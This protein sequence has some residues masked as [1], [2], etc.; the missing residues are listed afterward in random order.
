MRASL[1][2]MAIGVAVVVALFLAAESGLVDA[3]TNGD[4]RIKGNISWSGERIYHLPGDEYYD[5]TRINT[6][7]GER[8][9]C[10]EAEAQDAG[11]RRTMR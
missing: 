9:F 7:K 8:W 1:Q 5:A 10:T 2:R 11:W 4:C 6:A 3:V